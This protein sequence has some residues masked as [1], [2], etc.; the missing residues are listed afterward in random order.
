MPIR[1]IKIPEPVTIVD[2]VTREPMVI[3]G[4]PETTTFSQLVNRLMGNPLWGETLAAM[5]SQLAIELA[6]SQAVT[7]GGGVME[8]AEEDWSRLK[9]CAE[10][11]RSMI[12][13]P[14]GPQVVAGIGVNPMLGAQFVP[15]LMPIIDATTERPK[16]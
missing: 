3:D 12:N 14:M 1:Y 9:S 10:S 11:P 16:P 5:R 15:L 7:T 2:P 8:L 6:L 13:T 4:K